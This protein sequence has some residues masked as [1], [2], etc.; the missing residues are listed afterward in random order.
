MRIRVRPAHPEI[1]TANPEFRTG[2][3]RRCICARDAVAKDTFGSASCGG[4]I[5]CF[6]VVPRA[7]AR[8]AGLAGR[9][10]RLRRKR[11]RAIRST[12]AGWQG[13]RNITEL[14]CRVPHAEYPCFR[15]VFYVSGFPERRCAEREKGGGRRGATRAKSILHPDRG[16]APRSGSGHGISSTHRSGRI[17]RI[18]AP[19]SRSH[20]PS[21]VPTGARIAAFV[22]TMRSL[23]NRCSRAHRDR[24]RR[25]A[26]RLVRLARSARPGCSDRRHRAEA[27][28]QAQ[29]R[30]RPMQARRRPSRQSLRNK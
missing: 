2:R 21:R 29:S 7:R 12:R 22:R 23:P 28:K 27:G 15:G 17:A 1:R 13:A 3:V 16:V 6:T 20:A 4:A 25:A 10:F 9:G 19:N 8:A 11:L 5:A 14:D 18:P 26:A 30:T 24:R